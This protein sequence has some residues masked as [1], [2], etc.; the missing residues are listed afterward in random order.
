MADMWDPVESILRYKA[1][2]RCSEAWTE[3]GAVKPPKKRQRTKAYQWLL[4]V[5]NILRQY[6]G[7]GLANYLAP[8]GSTLDPGSKPDPEDPYS[9]PWLGIALD[10]GSD[11]WAA[12]Q[13]LKYGL[14]AN[15]EEF[16]D[17]SHDCWNDVRNALRETGLWN[18]VL[19]MV[20]ALNLSHAPFEEGRW[21][22]M[23]K[24]AFTEYHSVASHHDPIFVMLLP[25]IL[26]D[27]GEL[28]RQ[29]EPNIAQEVWDRLPDQWCWRRRGAKV[30]MCRFFGFM[31]ASVPFREIYHTKLLGMI[32]LG[33]KQGWLQ[34]QS[35]KNMVKK[36]VKVKDTG[37]DK[38]QTTKE[39]KKQV[40]SLFGYGNA[41][42][43][44]T[45]AMLE[46]DTYFYQLMI[47]VCSAP[48]VAWHQHQ[49]VILRSCEAAG[50]WFI[51]NALGGFLV[52]VCKVF[53][54]LW[55]T[56]DDQQ[57]ESMGFY[58]G[59]SAPGVFFP[60]QPA[61]LIFGS[62]PGEALGSK[63]DGLKHPAVVTEYERA[64]SALEYTLNCAS[65]RVRRCFW[66]VRG[67]PAQSCLLG[68]DDEATRKNA[69][70]M[71]KEDL[72][73]YQKCKAEAPIFFGKKQMS[74]FETRPVQQVVEIMKAQ[75]QNKG[76]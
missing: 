32:Y 73:G 55:S 39:S 63:P 41:M 44:V 24:D 29:A 49:N 59:G 33:L 72:D 71:L 61:G 65:N 40:G 47:E 19:V 50:P 43:L 11:S 5:D 34:K 37:A 10:R 27:W 12:K 76:K 58:S 64:A 3:G 48:L 18:H 69:R 57:V 7:K 4:A 35:I 36:V 21:F 70:K 46:P 17:Q 45:A 23:I 54:V 67:W 2:L 13:F 30:G 28:H 52:P 8:D 6:T 1:W 14:L 60:T 22:N 53:G 25:K 16:P 74:V 42:Q 15:I 66:A 56:S 9:W 68:A 20:L 62:K 51:K 31:T 38:K 75:Q 26:N